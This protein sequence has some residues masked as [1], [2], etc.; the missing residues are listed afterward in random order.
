M[1]DSY[2]LE[3]LGIINTNKVYRNLT[4]AELIEFAIQ[5]KEGI[6]TDNGSISI[7]TGK[8]TGRSPK[9]RFIVDQPSIHNQIDWGKINIPTTEKVFEKLYVRATAYL[10]EK[11]VFIYDG[12]VGHDMQTRMS[13]RIISD[14]ASSALFSTNMFVSADKKDLNLHNQADFTVIAVPRCKTVPE[15]DEVR[16]EVAI[17]VNFDKKI[18]IILGSAYG[19]EIK[20]VMFSI[21]N[22]LLPAKNIFPMHC[23]ANEGKDGNSALFFGLSGTGKTT[24][25]MDPERILIG[26]DEHGWGSDKIFNMEGGSYAKII[27]ITPKKEPRIFSAIRFGTLLENAVI[28]SDRTPDYADSKYT[29]NT[30]AAIPMEYIENAKMDGIC[31]IPSVIYFLTADAFGV[32]PP[33]S[34]LTKEQAMYHFMSGYT[35]KVAG[36]ET[37]IIEPLPTFSA[38]FGAPFMMRHPAVYAK[39]LGEKIE[40]YHTDVFLVNTGW[41]GG[42]YGIGSRIK[43]AYT[44]AMVSAALNGKLKNVEYTEEP[45]FGLQ[46]PKEIP[47][48]IVPSEILLP[49]NTWEDKE[50]YY[51]TAVTLA[52][53]FKENFEKFEGYIED[54]IKNAGPKIV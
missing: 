36:T 47:G 48:S 28:R 34:R 30:R 1:N 12:Y 13:L 41:A 25:S 33:I 39:M 10:Q 53:K 40:K 37:G 26:D 35:A 6:L 38:C 46:V 4:R 42:P 9:D 16:S 7:N 44:R 22:F 52:N 19:G 54:K 2:G 50:L 11:N 21:M 24:I 23:S 18:A 45:I 29:E 31:S 51:K 15:V 43:L 32:L 5:N 3:K 27:D 8:H 17:G 20:K 14:Y 49:K